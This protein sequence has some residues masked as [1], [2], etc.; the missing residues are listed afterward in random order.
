MPTLRVAHELEPELSFS[1]LDHALDVVIA[2]DS[3]NAGQRAIGL[4]DELARRAVDGLSF[5]PRLWPFELL[6]KTVW[7]T[8]ATHEAVDAAILIVAA[9][10]AQPFPPSIRHWTE[11][12]IQRKRGTPG[13]VIALLGPEGTSDPAATRRVEELRSLARQAG[14]DFFVPSPHQRTGMAAELHLK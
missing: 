2:C 12:V 13:A 14:L 10:S 6:A 11:G 5:I 1:G 8:V 9:D 7:R 4:L 3:S